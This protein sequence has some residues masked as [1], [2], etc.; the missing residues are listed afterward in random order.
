M[1][2]VT[3]AVIPAAGFGT[4]FLPVTKAVPKE[5]L[6]IVDTPA[7]HYI[8]QEA[9][10]SGITDV[11]I[12]T[13]RSKRVMEDYFDRNPELEYLLKN[14]GKHVALALEEE[15]SNMADIC[16]VRQKE[17]KGVG[18]ALMLAK[19]FVGNDPFAVLFGDDLV[20]N[21]GNPAT[22]QLCKAYET[23]GTCILGVQ[24]IPMSE[25]HKYGVVKPGLSKGRY[26]EVKGFVEKPK[27]NAPSNIASLGRYVLTPEIFDALKVAPLGPGNELYLTEALDMIAN[28]SGVYAYEFEG[29]R[30]D[31]GDKLGYMKAVTEYALRHSEVGEG[32]LAYLKELVK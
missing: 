17:M 31:T 1:K 28:G 23:T 26:T 21:P 6:N 30:Y 10:D 15:V 19:T 7:L 4:R 20:Y 11:L 12:I 14:A 16:F 9:L 5:M 13:G 18:N 29:T 27:E 32:Y 3:K 22:A 25:V 2:K 24:R 8:V